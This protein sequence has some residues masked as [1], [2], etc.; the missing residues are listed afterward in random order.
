MAE[1]LWRVSLQEYL[2]RISRAN[3]WDG[4]NLACD[5]CFDG[6]ARTFGNHA[7]VVVVVGRHVKELA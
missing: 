2:S 4:R 6:V 1:Q 5:F 3:I 7:F